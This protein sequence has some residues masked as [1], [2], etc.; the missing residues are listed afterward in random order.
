M[1]VTTPLVTTSH[2]DLGARIAGRVITPGAPDF[3][4]AC[5]AWHLSYLHRPALVV[6]PDSAADVA[7]AVRYAASH[8][9]K[10][11]VQ[12][13]GHG[14]LGTAAGSM[15]VLTHRL[16]HVQIDAD[17]WTARIGAGAKWEK[18][19]GPAQVH[20]LAP[21]LGSTP[22]VS[23]VGYTLG[24]GMGWLA[25]RYGLSIDHVRS[26]EIVTADG[27]I[28]QVSGETEPELFWALRGGGA[29]SLGVVTEMEIDLV[30]VSHVYA[31][32]LLYPTAA[33]QD[34]MGH[35]RNWLGQVPDEL[36]SSIVFMN[37]PPLEEVPEPIRGQSFVMVRGCYAGPDADGEALLS[38]WRQ[39]QTP[40]L[41]LWGPMPF[42]AVATISNDPVDPVLGYS[43]AEW[44]ADIGPEVVEILTRRVFRTEGPPSL[45]FA[46]IRHAGGAIARPPRPAAYGNRNQQHVLQLVGV[47]E[48]D[49]GLVRVRAD[50]ERVRGELSPHTSGTTYL[51]FLEGAE[52]IA[53]ARQG[54]DAASWDRLRA[55][56]AA[57]D[58]DNRFADGLPLA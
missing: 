40:V 49:A 41:D 18:V 27:W 32:N 4:A 1:T 16:D 47:A 51:N 25:R 6:V 43:T 45:V 35:Y 20:G 10:V 15:L 14:V 38:H 22:D 17:A 56:K 26:F 30:P 36:T 31:G 12:A 54:F 23:A 7:Q 11:T 21:L 55:V 37:F 53:R 46:E 39:W 33:A 3:H 2:D 57:A 58:P 9:L 5:S 24:G 48:D 19:L 34:V 13:T 42:S 28:R 50:V 29:G 8:G 52:K 44:L